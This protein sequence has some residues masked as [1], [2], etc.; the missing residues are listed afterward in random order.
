MKIPNQPAGC[1]SSCSLFKEVLVLLVVL[2][3]KLVLTA[4]LGRHEDFRLFATRVLFAL[5]CD[6]V[7]G[8][9]TTS[10]LIMT[11]TDFRNPI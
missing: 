4:V 3:C 5:I 11:I 10:F 9:H 2:L 8:M 1:S 6:G 7:L